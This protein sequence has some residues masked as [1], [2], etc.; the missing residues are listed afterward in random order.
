MASLDKTGGTPDKSGAGRLKTTPPETE[1]ERIVAETPTAS[2][3]VAVK[4]EVPT[5]VG[6]PLMTP[7]L[8]ESPAGSEPAVMDQVNGGVPP[9]V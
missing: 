7:P 1:I 2:W 9:D 5:V 3:T 6:I 4:V 8:R